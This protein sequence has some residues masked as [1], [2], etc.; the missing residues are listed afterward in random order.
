MP[1]FPRYESKGSLTTR[2][3]SAMAVEDTSGQMI[4]KV[5]EVGQTIQK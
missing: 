5:G 2:Q 3:P 1:E 4:E